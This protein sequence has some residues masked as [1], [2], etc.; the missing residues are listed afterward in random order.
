M[1]YQLL[2]QAYESGNDV[3][4]DHQHYGNMLRGR[5]Y[6][7][8]DTHFTLFNSGAQGG[9]LWAFRLEDIQYVGLVVDLPTSLMVSESTASDPCSN[10][11]AE[12]T[13]IS[14]ER[15]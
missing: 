14:P 5:V 4:L 13:N 1:F 3:V 8:D 9:I 11:R 10:H 7:L 2:K 15:D 12:G 6:D